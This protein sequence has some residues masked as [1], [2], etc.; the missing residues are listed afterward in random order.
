LKAL[1][2]GG[3]GMLARD[4]APALRR[5]GL[6]VEA[7]A[8]VRLD[9]RNSGHVDAVLAT[10]R[11]EI[12]VNCAAF[13]NVDLC[14]TDPL[15]PEINAR[16][17]ANLSRACARSGARLVQISTDFVFDGVK[18]SPYGEQDETAPASAYGRAKL[19]GEAAALAA[20]GA[21][22][23]R[24]SWLFGRGGTN[25]VETMMSRAD[26]GRTEVRVVGD[27]IGRP[28]ATADLAE[29]IAALVAAS[30]SGIVHFANA[31]EVSWHA[32]AREIFRIAGKPEIRVVEIASSE[33]GRPAKRP[34]YSV[35]STAKYERL[36]GRAPRDFRE[37]LREYLA[38]RR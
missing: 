18:R 17:V 22:V 10:F 26:E 25:F 31:G 16:A 34:A 28:T 6:D 5:A 29:A 33:L 27:Q 3:G 2:T 7:P 15:C 21:L 14:E 4:L 38:A 1:V 19:E 20:P 30:A 32:F 9:I 36:T 13:T 11:P 8:K 23:V 12:V 35:L 24:A 37:P